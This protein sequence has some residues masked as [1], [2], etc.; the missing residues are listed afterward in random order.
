MKIIHKYKTPNVSSRQNLKV[1]WITIH[2]TGGTSAINAARWLCRREAQA[3]A[4]YVIGYEGVIYQL[5]PLNKRT[6][7]VG[8]GEV[9]SNGKMLR[10]R[11][12]R[13]AIGIEIANPGPLYKFNKLDWYY[14]VGRKEVPYDKDKYGDPKRV[15][16]EYYS[17][18]S[19]FWAPYSERQ[20]K[21]LF[22]LCNKLCLDFNIS[23]SDIL[24][25]DE[26][27]LPPGRKLD[28]GPLFPW[29]RLYEH[30]ESG[31]M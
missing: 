26:V 11:C 19:S 10:G 21:S 5:A 17:K 9:Y 1:D 27:A 23:E 13:S 16:D 15:Y 2:Y 8:Q 14:V 24:G 20:L 7:H 22:N 6:W 3:S 12:D 29:K 30:L 25:H 28:P 31:R 18:V 4:H